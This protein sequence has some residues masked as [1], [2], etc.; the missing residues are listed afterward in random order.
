VQSLQLVLFE[1]W[2]HLSEEEKYPSHIQLTEPKKLT[3][4]TRHDINNKLTGIPVFLCAFY[5]GKL[6][7]I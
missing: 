2:W 3:S 7:A 5:P 4:I 1:G 6:Q